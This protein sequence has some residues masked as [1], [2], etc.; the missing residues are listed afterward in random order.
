M[1]PESFTKSA[2]GQV[3]Q[4]ESK[5]RSYWAFVPDPLPPKLDVDWEL[6]TLVADAT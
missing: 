1:R 6:A 5:G 4:A 2:P 3:V